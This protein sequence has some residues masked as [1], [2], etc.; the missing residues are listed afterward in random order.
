MPFLSTVNCQIDR[1]VYPA[2]SGI[3]PAISG[4]IFTCKLSHP[5]ESLLELWSR[6]SA[7][8]SIASG[9]VNAILPAGSSRHEARLASQSDHQHYQYHFLPH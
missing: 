1:T 8:D 7:K 3:Y 6:F 9:N 5:A 4:H 2:N